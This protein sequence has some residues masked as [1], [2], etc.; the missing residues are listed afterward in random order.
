MYVGNPPQKVRGLFATGSTNTGVL[1]KKTD[2]KGGK[3]KEYAY[4][5][6]ESK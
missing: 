4:D 5:D 2:L 3:K 1:N 6:E